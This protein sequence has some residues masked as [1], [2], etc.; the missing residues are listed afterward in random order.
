MSNGHKRLLPYLTKFLNSPHPHRSGRVCPMALG[1]LNGDRILLTAPMQEVE[2]EDKVV[3]FVKAAVKCIDWKQWS[4]PTALIFLFPDDFA[5]ETLVRIQGRVKIYCVK[6]HVMAGALFPA[7]NA[8]SLHSNDF[9]PLR[10][11][12]PTLVVRDMVPMDLMF[13]RNDLRFS[14]LNRMQFL[15]NFSRRFGSGKSSSTVRS[16]TQANELL[17]KYYL[18]TTIGGAVVCMA[19]YFMFQELIF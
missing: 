8:L 1:A 9:Y 2:S 19:A 18:F 10:T 5:I 7:N 15:R 17:R 13:L 6:Q 3:A 12:V 14:I 16:V 11:P 4:V